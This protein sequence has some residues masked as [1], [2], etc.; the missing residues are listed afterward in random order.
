RTPGPLPM[1]LNGGILAHEHFHAY[2]FALLLEKVILILDQW[3]TPTASSVHSGVKSGWWLPHFNST[4]N[5]NMGVLLAWNEGLA[6]FWGYLYS[7]DPQ[8][9]GE[10]LPHRLRARSLDRGVSPIPDSGDWSARMN[11]GA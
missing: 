9:I 11:H 5:H 2:F 10:S 7:G 8:F 6:D 4:L 1:A 3:P